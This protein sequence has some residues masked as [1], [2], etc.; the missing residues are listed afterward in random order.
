MQWL[1]ARMFKVRARVA[2]WRLAGW[3]RL[4]RW[5]GYADPNARVAPAGL[6]LSPSARHFVDYDV[7]PLRLNF[8]SGSFP[9]IAAWQR[10]ARDKLASLCGYETRRLAPVVAATTTHS[11]DGNGERRTVYLRARAGV[12]IPVNII[13]PAGVRQGLPV[14]LCLQGTNSG[15]H[16]SWGEAR[17]PADLEQKKEGYDIARQAAARGYLAVAIEQIGFGERSERQIVPRST[18]PCVDATMHALLLGRCL[19]GE[20]CT[21]IST[22]IDWLLAE[23]EALGLD[24]ARIH[25]MGHSA[26]G[27]VALVAAALDTRITAVLACGCLD[28]IRTSIGR[29]RDDQGQNVIPGILQWMEMD[30]L[31]GLVA[32]RPFATVA[33][34][35]D[36]IW[37]AAG[38]RR[39]CEA[40]RRAYDALEHPDRLI[41][42]SA[43][44]GHYFRP[45]QSWTALVNALA[46]R[47]N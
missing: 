40:A 1:D 44:G 4:R 6:A 30:D 26:G 3:L 46:S 2:A 38:A 10:Q 24:P 9:D 36:P 21:D 14:M 19:M 27:S 39:V 29:R 33:G 12:D 42:M 31:V 35:A 34:E 20:R 32:P 45:E 8:A 16:L 37:P 17:Y 23:H 25:I 7:A 15:A 18:A 41:V 28:F 22:V 5:L 47:E 13:A 43:P 11:L